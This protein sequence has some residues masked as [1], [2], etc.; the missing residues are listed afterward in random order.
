M[1]LFL[2]KNWPSLYSTT[3]LPILTQEDIFIQEEGVPQGS[4]LSVT[5]FA[6]KI[7][8]ILKQLPP[9]VRGSLYVDDLQISCHGKDMRYIERQLQTA[10]NRLMNWSGKNGF[11]FSPDKTTCLHFCRLKNLH[12]DPEIFIGTN[13][14][15]VSDC[16]RFLGVYFYKKLTFQPHI[17]HL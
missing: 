15:T 12:L 13:Q 11:N 7:N 9:T 10:V 6:I 16:M 3:I 17:S 2:F 8:N 1:V 5:L 14:I 4:V